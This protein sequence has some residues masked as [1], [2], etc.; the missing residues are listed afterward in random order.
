LEIK[1]SIPLSSV[2]SRVSNFKKSSVFF[3]NLD[4]LRFIA[5]AFVFLQHG[6]GNIFTSFKLDNLFLQNLINFL[7]INGGTGVSIFFV[8]SGFLI[9]F[10]IL[11]EINTNGKLDLKSFYIRR[12]LRIWPL[13]FCVVIFAFEIYPFLK[14]LIGIYSNLCSQSIYYYFFLSNFDSIN[15]NHFCPGQDAMI[16]GITWSVAIEEQFYLIW[17]LFFLFIPKNYLVYIFYSIITLSLCF[18]IL[19]SEDNAILYFHTLSV[20]G[21]LAV[22]GLGAYYIINGKAFRKFFES[23]HPKLILIGYCLGLTFCIFGGELNLWVFTRLLTSL[24]FLFI[25]LEQN[26]NNKS[27]YK[28]SRLTVFSKAG[29]YTY[30]YYLLHPIAILIINNIYRIAGV[31]NYT[32]I[33]TLINGGLALIIT[34]FISYISYHYFEAYFIKMKSRYSYIRKD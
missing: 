8:L 31:N 28:L 5:F 15:I 34:F 30:G 32:V 14:S 10:L 1:D 7:F 22:G 3:P 9:T 33:D 29:K 11:T 2:K 26:F 12:T 17:P 18:R 16:E 21:D 27:T 24:F 25:I 4:G 20:C 6:F 23:L 13:Y 19:H